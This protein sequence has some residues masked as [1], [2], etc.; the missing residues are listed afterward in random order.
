VIHGLIKPVF[1]TPLN[2]SHWA[3]RGLVA[4]YLMNAGCGDL[5]HDSCGQNDGKLIGAAPMSPTSGWVPGPHGPALAFPGANAYVRITDAPALSGMSELTLSLW[6]CPSSF[7]AMPSLIE[8]GT[9]ETLATQAY[10]IMINTSG[11][12]D[13]SFIGYYDGTNKQLQLPATSAALVLN[14]FQNVVVRWKSGGTLDVF[15]NAVRKSSTAAPV[16]TIINNGRDVAIGAE[17]RATIIRYFPGLIST[18]SIYNHFLS[19]EEIAYL[20]A[21]PWCM[22]D[23][24][25]SS[26]DQSLNAINARSKITG[27][28]KV[29][30]ITGPHKIRRISGTVRVKRIAA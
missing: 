19:A 14:V 11:K 18:V 10:N 26:W 25:E 7:A 15:F 27:Q 29:R 12:L 17:L 1:G 2:R 4:Q 3:S 9:T 16:G 5:I 13:S 30:S 21:F 28:S 20:Y 8:K 6:V 24:A 23:R 22:Y